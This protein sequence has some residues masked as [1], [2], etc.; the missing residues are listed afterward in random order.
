MA[1]TKG[2]ASKAVWGRGKR[3][4]EKV[5]AHSTIH[6]DR[7]DAFSILYERIASP[8]EVSQVLGIPL[9]TASFHINE[10]KDDGVIELVKTEQRRGAVEHYYRATEAPEVDF[11]E[12]KALPKRM[13]REIVGLALQA[14]VANSLASFRHERMED[15]DDVCVAWMPLKL[16]AAGQDEVTALQVEILDRLKQIEERDKERDQDDSTP[17]RIAATLWFERALPRGE[18][19]AQERPAGKAKRSKK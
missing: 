1:K 4:K 7:L 9:G 17:V 10:L 6:P 16:S 3:S 12:W 8:K 11:D 13:R 2:K 19:R 5:I 15:D 14:V 18:E